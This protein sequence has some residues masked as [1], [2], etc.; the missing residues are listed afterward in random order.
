MNL[1]LLSVVFI[2]RLGGITP[3]LISKSE[4]FETAGTELPGI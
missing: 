1:P 2:S 3:D 4:L